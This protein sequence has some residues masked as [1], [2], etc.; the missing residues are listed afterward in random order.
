[1]KCSVCDVQLLADKFCF[2]HKHKFQSEISLVY[3]S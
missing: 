2:K 1:M 3:Q